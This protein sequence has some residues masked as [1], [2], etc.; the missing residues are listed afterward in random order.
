MNEP[1]LLNSLFNPKVVAIIGASPDPSKWG[2]W[3]AEQVFVHDYIRKVYFVNPKEKIIF[4][5]K[6]LASI[7]LI[8]EPIDVAV[9]A[10]PL[11]LYEIVVDQLLF[12]G[13][14]FI[15][16]I[17]AG[18]G[19]RDIV[20]LHKEQRIAVKVRR[21]GA[22]MVGPNCA[23]VYDGY[24]PFHCMPVGDYTPGPISI[25]SQSGGLIA[26]LY[27]RL[28][29]VHLGYSKAISVGNINQTPIAEILEYMD[30]DPNT[31]LIVLHM[32]ETKAIPDLTN[33]SKPVIL[34]APKV[35]EASKQAVWNHTN[36]ELKEANTYTSLRDIVPLIQRTLSG[37]KSD[38]GKRMAVIVDSGGLGAF[39]AAEAQE[40]GF[41]LPLPSH[42]LRN[43]ITER[44][45]EDVP[46]LRIGN[47]IDMISIS[48]GFSQPTCEILDVLLSS[49]EYD[50]AICLL[51]L[52]EIELDPKL[53]FYIG[54]NMAYVIKR[55][56]KPAMIVCKDFNRESIKALIQEGIPVYRDIETA[57]EMMKTLLK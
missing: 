15:I 35:T 45:L 9:V 26:D 49:D 4:G 2:N 25:I 38:G 56:N 32:E 17:T 11:D 28:K 55:Y 10:V 54:L 43:L 57:T 24:A 48:S 22:H 44:T 53:E 39:L 13:V 34:L 42:G 50:C 20:G 46:N 18:F 12:H 40:A 37:M 8:P 1:L 7:D 23:G 27:L 19:E 30:A 14:K 52:I 6:S 29:E 5:Q 16:G 3:L 21:S 51:Y 36:S 47:P 31:K 33:I 41:E